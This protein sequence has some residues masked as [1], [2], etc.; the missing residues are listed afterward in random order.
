MKNAYLDFSSDVFYAATNIR[1][2]NRNDIRLVSIEPIVSFS[3]HKLTTISGKRLKDLSRA[4]VVCLMCK[5]I[6]SSW[7]SDNL[8][9]GFDH[10]LERRQ[11]ELTDNNTL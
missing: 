6:S 10:D 11:Q 3:D 2:A 4:Q 9:N 1:S 8:S 5:V 7:G